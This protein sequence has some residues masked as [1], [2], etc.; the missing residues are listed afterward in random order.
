MTDHTIHVGD[1][2]VTAFLVTKYDDG[3]ITVATR[4]VAGGTAERWSF[5]VETE[6][7]S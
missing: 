1:D 6:V 4:S 2:G 7:A 3:T 5:P